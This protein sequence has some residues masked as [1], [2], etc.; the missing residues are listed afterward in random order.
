MKKSVSALLIAAA[1]FSV[2][3]AP[4]SAYEYDKD[5]IKKE[6]KCK[7]QETAAYVLADLAQAMTIS[8]NIFENDLLRLEVKPYITTED[9]SFGSSVRKSLGANSVIMVT[10]GGMAGYAMYIPVLPYLEATI[11]N[12]TDQPLEI[13]LD[14]SQITIGGYSG[15]GVMAGVKFSEASN[16][17]QPPL[18]IFPNATK[19]VA[20]WRTDFTFFEGTIIKDPRWLPPF[21]LALNTNI[22][23]ETILKV[24]D[25]YIAFVPSAV[26]DESKLHWRKI[27]K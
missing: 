9:E 16:A 10:G 17:I 7:L 25:K 20:L 22:L 23:G 27:K 15:R 11:T 2:A 6:F 5:A 12:K 4:V 14:R 1:F 19:T 8:D 13:D 26:I 21:D 24:N 3:A 18:I